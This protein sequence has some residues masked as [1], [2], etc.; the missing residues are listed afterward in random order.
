MRKKIQKY[1]VKRLLF[2]LESSIINK[3]LLRDILQ[4]LLLWLSR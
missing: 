3:L 1:G 4:H 2:S